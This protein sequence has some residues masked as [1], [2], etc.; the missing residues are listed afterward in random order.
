VRVFGH[1]RA[2]MLVAALTAAALVAVVLAPRGKSDDAPAGWKLVWSDEFSGP[3]NTPPDKTKW[4]YDTGNLG[5]NGELEDYTDSTSNVRLNGTGQLEIVARKEKK[6]G[7][8]YTSGRILTQGLYTT[9]YGR[10]E[11][12]IK[13]PSGQ[14]MWPAFWMLG[15]DIQAHGWPQCGEIDI[16]ENIGREPATNHGSMHGPGYSGANGLTGSV[17]LSSGA[18][19]DAYHDYAIEWSPQQVTFFLDGKAYETQKRGDQ[20]S[21]S[22][23]VYDHPFFLLLNVA[24]GGDWP[25]APDATTQFPQTMSVDWV[26]VYK[27]SGPDTT[28]PITPVPHVTHLTPR[29]ATLAWVPSA[30]ESTIAGYDIYRNGKKVGTTLLTA[31][32]VTGLKPRTSYAFAVVA[33]DSAGNASPRSRTVTVRTCKLGKRSC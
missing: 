26:R 13:L 6:D 11:A 10:I 28:P 14:G 1:R 29:S 30:D 19:S 21:G 7:W 31:Y 24:V 18:L 22:A 20:P 3:A 4:T 12:R 2:I 17:S 5:V 25:G 32:K 23:W 16:M 8:D 33:R 27:Q 15:D 9:T